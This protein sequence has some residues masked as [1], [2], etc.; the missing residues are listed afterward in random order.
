MARPLFNQ[1]VTDV[2]NHDAFFRTNMEIST[3]RQPFRVAKG[4]PPHSSFGILCFT[5]NFLDVYNAKKSE[6]FTKTTGFREEVR[7]A[8][9]CVTDGSG[10]VVPY[11]FKEQ[12]VIR[13]PGPIRSFAGKLLGR[14]TYA[15]EISFVANGVTYRC[16]YYLVDGIYPELATLVKTIPEP[17]ND[18]H[19]P[20]HPTTPHE[21]FGISKAEIVQGMMWN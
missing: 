13:D 9:Y 5:A 10:S 8:L 20:T 15:P 19:N 6:R 16:G 2:S 18:D 11:D 7:K 21:N 12:Y 17:A 4:A 1:I 14:M 3:G